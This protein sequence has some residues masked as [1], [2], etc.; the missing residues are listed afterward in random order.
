MAGTCH[1][2][3]SGTQLASRV[4]NPSGQGAWVIRGGRVHTYE[5]SR[6]QSETDPPPVPQ[7]SERTST[8]LPH[9]GFSFF[10]SAPLRYK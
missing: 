1:A 3:R 9:S 10:Y 7:I 6:D 4:P 8:L 2:P 5:G